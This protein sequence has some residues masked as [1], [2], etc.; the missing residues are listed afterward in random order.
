MAPFTQSTWRRFATTTL[1]APSR[2]SLTTTKSP[3]SNGK[4]SEWDSW[5]LARSR[6]LSCRWPLTPESWSLR[7]WTSSSLLI[8]LS[9]PPVRSWIECSTATPAWTAL[10]PV[11][12]VWGFLRI[13]LRPIKSKFFR[14]EDGITGFSLAHYHRGFSVLLGSPII[15]LSLPFR[16]VAFILSKPFH[17]SFSS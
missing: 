3:T 4:R 9:P 2:R 6:N 11:Q 7:S 16:I 10:T 8:E 13:C 1:H 5:R 14:G 15:S 12:I 17:S